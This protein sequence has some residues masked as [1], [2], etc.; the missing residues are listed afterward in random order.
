MLAFDWLEKNSQNWGKYSP[1]F[2]CENDLCRA[3]LPDKL[4]TFSSTLCQIWSL[5]K[6]NGYYVYDISIFLKWGISNVPFCSIFVPFH[7]YLDMTVVVPCLDFA[8]TSNLCRAMLPNYFR[9]YSCALCQ[10]RA[11]EKAFK[12]PKNGKSVPKISVLNACIWLAKTNSQI[13][14]A[15]LYGF[16]L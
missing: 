9:T 4:G 7:F 11:L 2:P 10:I 14:H 8:S 16:L 15:I 5:E 12:K 1:Y 3:M 13:L 6:A